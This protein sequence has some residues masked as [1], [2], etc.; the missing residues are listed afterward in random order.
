MG[1]SFETLLLFALLIAWW[2]AMRVTVNVNGADA[3]VKLEGSLD[4]TVTAVLKEVQAKAGG[5]R[6]LLFDVTGVQRIASVSIKDWILGFAALEAKGYQAEFEGCSMAFLDTATMVPDFV[7]KRR[8]HSIMP[9][10]ACEGCPN[11]ETV[12]VRIE[13]GAANLP[14][15]VVCPKCGETMAVS[16]SLATDLE[17]LFRG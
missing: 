6:R 5:A 3:L 7:A 2:S 17:S 8:I 14:S 11:E 15:D 4:E 12:L 1:L 16:E 9:L 10:L 13:N